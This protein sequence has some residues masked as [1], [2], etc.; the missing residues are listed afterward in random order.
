MSHMLLRRK[1]RELCNSTSTLLWLEGAKHERILGVSLQGDRLIMQLANGTT[2]VVSFE[3]FAV[4][5]VGLQFWAQ[6][7]PGVLYKWEQV[8]KAS[9]AASDASSPA[10]TSGNGNDD[11]GHEPPP[12][13]AA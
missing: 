10:H 7:R 8:P 12:D 1:L 6:G 5:A 11:D 3:K 13:V 2:R 9:W 4:T